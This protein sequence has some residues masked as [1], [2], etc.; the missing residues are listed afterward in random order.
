MHW[1]DGDTELTG[2]YDTST[3]TVCERVNARRLVRQLTQ[4]RNTASDFETEPSLCEQ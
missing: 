4:I 1:F 2:G 3:P